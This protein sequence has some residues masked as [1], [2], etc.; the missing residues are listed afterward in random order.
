MSKPES[1]DATMIDGNERHTSLSEKFSPEL[2]E[3]NKKKENEKVNGPI[4]N[5][6]T[7]DL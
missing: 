3:A 5:T 6:Q 2:E 1:F 7:L 4:A